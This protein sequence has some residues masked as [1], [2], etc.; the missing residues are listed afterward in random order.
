MLE[1]LHFNFIWISYAHFWRCDKRFFDACKLRRLQL[2]LHTRLCQ[3]INPGGHGPSPRY[4]GRAF[5]MNMT[6]SSWLWRHRLLPPASSTAYRSFSALFI[7]DYFSSKI[8]RALSFSHS[9]IFGF[10]MN[11]HATLDF[12][13]QPDFR[14]LL[15]SIL[16][17][18]RLF[19]ALACLSIHLWGSFCLF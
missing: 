6:S 17:Y 15:C 16:L 8:T 10:L 1:L 3:M 13:N 5:L 18:F 2:Q 4:I 19:R 12:Y 7:N 11:Y 14:A 9:S